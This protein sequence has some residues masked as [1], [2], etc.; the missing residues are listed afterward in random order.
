MRPGVRGPSGSELAGL[1]IFLAASFLIPFVGGLVL[2]ALLHTSPLFLFI[3][4]VVGIGAAIAAVY[5]RLRRYL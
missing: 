4:L 5:G 1:S 3:G 2:D